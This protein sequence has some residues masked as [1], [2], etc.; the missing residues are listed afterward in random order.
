MNLYIYHEYQ[1][2]ESALCGVHCLNALLQRPAFSEVDLATI[3]KEL[4]ES[5]RQIMAS[6]GPN[7][8]DYLKYLGEASGNVG[9]DGNFSL[10]VLTAA[11]NKR[12]LECV[13]LTSSNYYNV[14]CNLSKENAFICNRG[15]HWFTIRKVLEGEWFNFNSLSESP[16]HMSESNL[17]S[18]LDDLFDKKNICIYA[19]RGKLPAISP[20]NRTS[21]DS[22]RWTVAEGSNRDDWDLK[23]AIEMSKRDAGEEE[24]ISYPKLGEGSVSYPKLEGM[25]S[26]EGGKVSYPTLEPPKKEKV[27]KVDQVKTA[28]T[29]QEQIQLMNEYFARILGSMEKMESRL[30]SVE[31]SFANIQAQQKKSR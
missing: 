5:E 29:P 13:P 31:K 8:S 16:E 2:K 12:G 15:S 27:V 14:I 28:T 17:G 10:Q 18:F 1:G 4:D 26:A 3:A 19:I 25:A 7:S 24:K 23:V 6:G 22:G 21:S 30:N 20:E 11:L 9:D